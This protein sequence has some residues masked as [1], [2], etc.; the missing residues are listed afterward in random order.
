MYII[1]QA[2]R[3][4]SIIWIFQRKMVWVLSDCIF[5]FISRLFIFISIKI[6]VTF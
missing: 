1:Q 5:D 2:A 4:I 3:G 6:I